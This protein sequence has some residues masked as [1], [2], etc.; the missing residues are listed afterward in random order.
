MNLNW[1]KNVWRE[2]AGRLRRMIQVASVAKMK[3]F[4]LFK[5]LLKRCP[6]INELCYRGSTNTLSKKESGLVENRQVNLQ[7]KT[8]EACEDFLLAEANKILAQAIS[9]P[10]GFMDTNRIAHIKWE[11]MKM[12]ERLGAKTPDEMF[13]LSAK[14]F[15]R[16]DLVY[17]Q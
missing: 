1:L 7:D 8:R 11:C 5:H 15:N 14:I 10:E 12:A 16:L 13:A 17:I 2:L 9:F 4:L 3:A 6:I